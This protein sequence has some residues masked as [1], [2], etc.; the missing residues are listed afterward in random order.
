MNSK[1][2]MFVLLLLIVG[3]MSACASQASQAPVSQPTEAAAPAT[4]AATSTSAASTE[5]AATEPA[6]AGST[7]SFASD[8]L[9]M[10]EN[11]CANCH[12]A[13]KTEK[14]LSLL[15]YAEIMA[16]SEN[17]AVVLPGD[18]THSKLAELVINQ[19]MPK[20]GPKLTPSQTQLIVDWINQ[21]AQDN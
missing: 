9:P 10:L 7:V 17:G 8:I 13:D 19:K 20:R 21:G 16:G 6:A 11:R 12:G 3:L 18:A 14:G 2:V 1:K 15:S 4:E 5:P